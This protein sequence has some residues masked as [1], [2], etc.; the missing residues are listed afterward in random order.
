VLK[1]FQIT[2]VLFAW[3]LATGVQWDLLQ[4]AGWARM[5]VS[6]T[7]TMSIAAAAK[8]TFGD[9]MC[10]VCK[11]VNEAKHREKSEIPAAGLKAKVIL[12][13]QPAPSYFLR[14]PEPE[15]WLPGDREPRSAPRPSPPTPPPRVA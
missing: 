7:G 4:V 12:V 6:Y 2:A 1:R 14:A 5:F 15:A 8:K 3:L 11:A 13:F 9:E 10:S